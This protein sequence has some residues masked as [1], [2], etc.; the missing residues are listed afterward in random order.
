M[1]SS[2]YERSKNIPISI[3]S[4][5]SKKGY[6]YSLNT[7]F[8]DPTKSSPP[9]DFMMKLRMRMNSYNSFNNLDNLDKE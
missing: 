8:F 6:E 9:N 5:T 2:I 1:K 4:P 7:S 3:S